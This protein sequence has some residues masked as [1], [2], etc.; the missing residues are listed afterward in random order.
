MQHKGFVQL[1]SMLIQLIFQNKN[2][3]KLWYKISVTV[4]FGP[5]KCSMNLVILF[6]ADLNIVMHWL[7]KQV[8][9]L[10]L[11]SFALILEYGLNWMCQK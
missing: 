10:E 3:Q 11:I 5:I 7:S 4:I 6:Q 8:I 1:I 2:M 9:S